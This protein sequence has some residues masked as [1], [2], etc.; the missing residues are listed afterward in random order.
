MRARCVGRLAM[1][2]PGPLKAKAAALI[3]AVPRERPGRRALP[4]RCVV[5]DPGPIC[6]RLEPQSAARHLWQPPA[7]GAEVERVGHS[8]FCPARLG[9]CLGRSRRGTRRS[10][11]SASTRAMG[12]LLDAP[13]L[14]VQDLLLVLVPKFLAGRGGEGRRSMR[15]GD[16][17][18]QYDTSVHCNKKTC[19]S[20]RAGREPRRMYDSARGVGHKVWPRRVRMTRGTGNDSRVC[21]RQNTGTGTQHDRKTLIFRSHSISVLWI[22]SSAGCRDCALIMLM[23]LLAHRKESLTSLDSLSPNTSSKNSSSIYLGMPWGGA[24]SLNAI[25]LASSSSDTPGSSLRTRSWTSW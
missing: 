19:L 5:G 3:L 22:E 12:G 24:Q 7:S 15:A 1:L 21:T 10:S 4:R 8:V 18:G 23:K 13:V 25:I 2:F 9:Q 16:G 11:S 14:R 17:Q 6:L 20:D